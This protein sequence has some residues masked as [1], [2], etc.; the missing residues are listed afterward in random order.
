MGRERQA[1][2]NGSPIRC[3]K[4]GPLFQ[5]PLQPI[6]ILKYLFAPQGFLWPFNLLYALLAVACWMYFTPALER[7]AS[8]KI[9]WMAEL[10]L[11]NVVLL[12]LI[13]GGLHLRLYVT[14][15]QG[16]KFKYTDKWLARDSAKFLFRNQKYDNI[17]WNLTSGAIAWTGWEAVTLWLYANGKIPYV[18][19][20]EHPV[21]GVFL[22]V[23]IIFL[24]MVHFY[25]V[26]RLIH[27]K[28]LYK[29]SHYLHHR[30]F[31]VNFGHESV[32]LDK[33]FGSFHDGSPEAHE[34]MLARRKIQ[35]E[36]D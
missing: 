14:R 33:W 11:R 31:T 34:V 35:I 10:Y 17:F 21:Y 8:F 2:E 26:H 7:A 6:K 25:W 15:G 19:W 28:P 4:R 12:I 3:R 27:W 18:A 24:R 29:I 22:I 32:P 20:R 5:W 1:G 36:A 16:C 30:Y 23:A 13:A 9:G